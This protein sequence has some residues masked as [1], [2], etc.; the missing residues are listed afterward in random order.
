MSASLIAVLT[1]SGCKDST[2]PASQASAPAASSV[3]YQAAKYDPIHFKP[4]IEQATDQQCLNCHAEVLKPAARKISSAGMEASNVKGWYQQL[5][6]YQGEQETFHRRHLET[7][8]AKQLMNLRCTTCHQGNDPRDRAPG[9]SATAQPDLTL[10]KTV[11]AETTCLKCHGQMN[12]PVMGLPEPWPQM[13]ASFQNNCLLC[14]TAIRTTRHQVT[15]L[16]AKAIEEMAAK[17]DGGDVCF[18]CHGGRAWY[19]I[20]YPFPRHAWPEMATETPDWAKDRPTES[21]ARFL[22]STTGQGEKK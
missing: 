13:K 10:R 16:N 21:E 9:S 3:S 6:T 5:S 15:Y 7:A 4:A 12:W 2:S 18:G 17:P 20:H 19:R 8:L 11:S 22:I 1:A 14:H